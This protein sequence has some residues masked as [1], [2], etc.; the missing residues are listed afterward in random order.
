MPIA[1]GGASVELNKAQRHQPHK[2][3]NAL[4]HTIRKAPQAGIG[5]LPR[6]PGSS[7]YYW[8]TSKPLNNDPR[9]MMEK[10]SQ[11]GGSL[12]SKDS[13]VRGVGGGLKKGGG[14]H[15]PRNSPQRK[16]GKP[17]SFLRIPLR[18]TQ[19]SSNT[20]NNSGI[21][22]QTSRSITLEA[23]DFPGPGKYSVY[24]Q[25]PSPRRLPPINHTSRDTFDFR[26]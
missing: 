1:S 4:S 22:S 26:S 16:K 6:F 21:L 14:Y 19:D 17:I 5:E 7:G 25:F 2:E 3:V 23:L 10:L 15:S 11:M 20:N 13:P 24:S 9:P 18:G 12:K 8:D